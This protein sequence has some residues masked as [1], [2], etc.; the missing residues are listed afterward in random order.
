M[1]AFEN[2]TGAYIPVREDR[3]RRTE[4][5]RKRTLTF[6]GQHQLDVDWS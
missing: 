6:A 2:R 1:A 5:P 4:G 3:K